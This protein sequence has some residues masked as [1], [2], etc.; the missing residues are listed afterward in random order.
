ME[1]EI[2]KIYRSRFKKMSEKITNNNLKT[3][4]TQTQKSQRLEMQVISTTPLK[5]R[6]YTNNDLNINFLKNRNR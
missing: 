2:K 4:I 3:K 6:T 1:R 5:K